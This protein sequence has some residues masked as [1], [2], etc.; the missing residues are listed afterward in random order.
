MTARLPELRLPVLITTGRYD[1]LT[2]EAVRPPAEGI[3]GARW[4]VFEHSAHLATAEEP[5]R[6]RA[7]V[8]GFL[9]EA[10]AAG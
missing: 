9:T 2:P 10:E 6:Y 7:V 8:D 4:E 3:P 5:E 1:E